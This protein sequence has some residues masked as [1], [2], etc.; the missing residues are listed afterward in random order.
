MISSLVDATLHS[1][2]DAALPAANW[3]LELLDQVGDLQEA[4]GVSIH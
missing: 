4:T 3:S 2:D 1:V